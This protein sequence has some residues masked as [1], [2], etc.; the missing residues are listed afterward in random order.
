[1]DFS[2]NIVLSFDFESFLTRNENNS[3]VNPFD[4]WMVIILT[5]F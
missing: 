5:A 2:R 1:M 4:E 3:F